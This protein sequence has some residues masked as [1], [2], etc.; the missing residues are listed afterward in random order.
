M[1]FPALWR[2]P[3]KTLPL[4]EEEV[5]VWRAALNRNPLSVQNLQQTLAPEEQRRAERFHFQED[6]EHF[7]VGRGLLRIILGRYLDME[8]KHLRFCYSPYGKPA[9]A[10]GSGGNALQFNLS[11]SHGMALYAVTRRRDLGIDLEQIR[12][13]WASEQIAARFFAPGEVAQLRA[14][15]ANMWHE[16]FFHCW[17]RKEAY[18]KARGE[19]LSLPLDKF[20]VSLAPGES[21]AL[22][23]T[24]SD[25]EEASR[26]SMKELRVGPGYA[27]ALVVQ[28]HDWQPQCW[29]L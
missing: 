14:L 1:V 8:P 6:R 28:G 20:E 13:D 21:A 11:H 19:G 24:K 17:T 23:S 7:I 25:P 22:L 12:T 3:P 2:L 15:P 18:I 5:H 16:A 26:W 27:A 9:L 29:Q 4:G 10:E